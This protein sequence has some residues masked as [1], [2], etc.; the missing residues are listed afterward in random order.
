MNWFKGKH[1]WRWGFFLSAVF[2]FWLIFPV[3]QGDVDNLGP[4]HKH[5]EVFDTVVRGYEN[6]RLRWQVKAKTVWTGY[7]PFLFRG[8]EIGPG[9]VFDDQGEAIINDIFSGQVQVNSKTKILYAY[10]TVSAYF[11]PRKLGL[12]PSALEAGD[13]QK[14]VRV[15][16]GGLKYIESAKRTYLTDTVEIIQGS[17]RIVPHVAAEL[18]NNTNI[19]LI[20]EGF[21][22]FLEDMVVSG[23]H[24]EIV[25]DDA[26]SHIQEVTLVRQGRPTTN[27]EMDSRERTLREKTTILTADN[28]RVEQ[29]DETYHITVSGNVLVRQEGKSFSGDSG[30]YDSANDSLSLSGNVR[31]VLSDLHWLIVPERRKAMKNAD[32]QKTLGLSTVITSDHLN[33]DP[34]SQ[35]LVLLGNVHVKQE[36]K[37]VRCTKIVYDDRE[38]R[39]ILSGDVTIVKQGEDS[40]TAST[41]VV[42][43]N[44]ESYR[45]AGK[46]QTEFKIKRAKK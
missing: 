30:I 21:Q 36:D 26:I 8:E 45:A 37:D 14:P 3:F 31:M 33:F 28:M 1:A 27:T 42:D 43:L 17:A 35:I 46:I 19:V 18:D 24:M 6:A 23:N 32:I 9:V 34:E 44:D 13:T 16:A 22:M 38:Q 25:I 40:L 2:L 39:V 12:L 41:L 29:N 10:D 4:N 15:T 11:I 5:V 20:E 7:N